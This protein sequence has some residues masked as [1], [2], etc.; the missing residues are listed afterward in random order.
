MRS[1]VT[2]EREKYKGNQ[3]K[4]IREIKKTLKP[5]STEPRKM[6]KKRVA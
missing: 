1:K 4:S 5:N 3:E 2:F 6:S